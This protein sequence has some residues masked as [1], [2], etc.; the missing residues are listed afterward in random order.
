MLTN[1]SVFE[2]NQENTDLT[3]LQ[4]ETRKPQGLLADDAFQTSCW[5]AM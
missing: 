4:A 1:V 3:N 2:G 5:A